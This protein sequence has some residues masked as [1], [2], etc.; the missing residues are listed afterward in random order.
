LRPH[1][2]EFDFRASSAMKRDESWRRKTFEVALQALLDGGEPGALDDEVGVATDEPRAIV[3]E[4]DAARI[5]G[6]DED[7][8]FPPQGDARLAGLPPLCDDDEIG[9]VADRRFELAPVKRLER[10]VNEGSGKK[11]L[12]EAELSLGDDKRREDRDKRRGADGM[13]A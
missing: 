5:V 10:G 11:A 2:S 1:N 4:R 8:R 9:G 3:E 13:A 6:K 7:R 12:C